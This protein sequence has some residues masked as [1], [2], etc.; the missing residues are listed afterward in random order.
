[1]ISPVLVEEFIHYGKIVSAAM[2]FVGLIT[3]LYQKLVSP[4]VRKVVHIST[5]IDK[6][7]T[8]C[9]PTIQA[10]LDSQDIVLGGLRKGHEEFRVQLNQFTTRQDGI[11]KIA[12]ATHTALL[13]HLE[14]T[15]REKRKKVKV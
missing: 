8:N 2:A 3:F 13:N 7:D 6:L 10:S 15:S 1:M 12:N 14:N 9:I 11:E 5:T 4:V